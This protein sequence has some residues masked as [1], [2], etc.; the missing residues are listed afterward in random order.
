MVIKSFEVIEYWIQAYQ[1][2]KISSVI[3]ISVYLITA[4]LKA[5]LVFLKGS[6]VQYAIIYTLDSVIIGVAFIV[7]YIKIREE[8][9]PWR[10]NF[11]YAKYIL[12]QSWYL[13][14]SGL[15]VTLYMRIDQV[16][17]GAMFPTKE[18]VGIYSVAVKIAEMWYFV[19]MAIITS[20]K[21]VIMNN[22]NISEDK[23]LQSVQLLY[24]IVAWISIGFGIIILILSKPLVLILYGSEYLKAASILTVNVWAG[25]FAM[26][27]SARSLWLITERLQG[28]TLIYTTAGVIVN[29]FMNYIL[30]PDYGGFGAAMAT[31]VAQFFAN[32]IVLALF[33]KTR[34]SS[35]MFWK[36]FLPISIFQFK[37]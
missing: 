5:L 30:I 17:L 26:L 8:I 15:M 1:K 21:P 18:E 34:L 33:K 24:T 9:T 19:P 35:V 22:K 31:L 11:R 32:M 6:L 2:A 25:T 20:F 12:S 23:Y 10:F 4:G 16:M 37:K 28:Y 3:R 7:A 27:G 36:S 14:I 29:I 13:I